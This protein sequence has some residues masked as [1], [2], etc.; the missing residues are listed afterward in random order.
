MMAALIIINVLALAGV[1]FPTTSTSISNL[2]R[3]IRV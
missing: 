2:R 3:C 1:C